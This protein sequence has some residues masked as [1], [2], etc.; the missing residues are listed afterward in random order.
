M[1]RLILLSAVLCSHLA[2]AYE[3]HLQ[4]TPQPG[5][6]SLVVAGYQFDANT[7]RVLGNCSYYTLSAS[8][9]RGGHSIRTD[10]YGA[11]SWDLQGNLVSLTPQS[12]PPPAPAQSF[13]RGTEIIYAQ[14][15]SSSTGV[16]TRGFGFVDTLSSHY[17]WVTPNNGYAVIPDAA[18]PI[19]VTLT[20]DGDFPLAFNSAVA[21]PIVSGLVTASAGTATVTSSTCSSSVQVGTSCSVSVSYN[22]AAIK[23]TSSPYG[24]AYT[25]ITISLVT[26]SGAATEFVEGF[27]VTGVPICDD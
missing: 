23:C 17:S 4:F 6:R 9:G 22:P 20:S 14:Y 25:K 18:Y 15:G 12:V 26:D 3:Y 1:K 11:C 13:Q 16:D 7:N 24:Y 8:S 10:R 27:T 2:Y 21:T 19:T 5:A